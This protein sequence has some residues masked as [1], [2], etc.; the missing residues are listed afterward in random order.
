[1][2]KIAIFQD[3][4]SFWVATDKELSAVKKGPAGECLQVF[5]SK[6]LA[7][8]FTLSA[9]SIELENEPADWLRVTRI[10]DCAMWLNGLKTS[11]ALK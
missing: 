2:K 7:L 4:S 8:D 10:I 3:F 9:T 11:E 5:T 6:K 1:M